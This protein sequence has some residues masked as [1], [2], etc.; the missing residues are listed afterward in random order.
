VPRVATVADLAT[1]ATT[2]IVPLV[3]ATPDVSSTEIRA[4][5][6]R[7]DALDGLVAEPVAQY[8]R[9]HGLYEAR[10]NW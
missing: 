2:A 10:P 9:R 1:R 7:G 4:R 8:I 6:S 3:A 5:A